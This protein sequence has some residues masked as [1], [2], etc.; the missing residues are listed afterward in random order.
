MRAATALVFVLLGSAGCA[1]S[2]KPR[3]T[4]RRRPS[5]ADIAGAGHD[6]SVAF[7]GDEISRLG[8]SV[9]REEAERVSERAH[10]G[11]RELARDYRVIRPALFHNFLVNAGVRERGLC[12]Q[13][14]EDLMRVVS[15]LHLAT[16]ELHWGT[17][18]PGTWREHNCVVVTAREQPFRDGVVLDAWR[19][20]GRLFWSGVAADHYPWQEERDAAY[21]ERA[22][23]RRAP[24]PAGDV[25]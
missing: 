16:V 15:S 8:S 3:V 5:S 17:A 22:T 21:L 9:A 1:D 11:A 23:G 13:W 4:T 6:P 7:L 25:R 18:R 2:I 10:A 14:T 24:H 12:F 19:H 20:S